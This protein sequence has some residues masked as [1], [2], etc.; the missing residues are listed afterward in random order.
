MLRQMLGPGSKSGVTLSQIEGAAAYEKKNFKALT[1]A[2]ESP[3]Y[4]GVPWIA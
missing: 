2:K 3:T 1:C 4:A